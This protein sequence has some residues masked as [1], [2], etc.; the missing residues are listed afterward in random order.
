MGGIFFSIYAND[1][2]SIFDAEMYRSFE[3]INHRGLDGSILVTESTKTME[4]RQ[5]D[6]L[7]KTMTRTE[8]ERFRKKYTFAHGY[9]RMSI[10]DITRNG[11]QPFEIC[12]KNTGNIS[13]L[14]CNGE[15]YNYN[16]LQKKYNFSLESKSDVEIILHLYKKLG[17]LETINELDGEY[18]FIITD[19]LNTLDYKQCNVFVV[20]DFLGFKPLYMVYHKHREFFLFVSEMKAIPEHMLKSSNFEIEEVPPGT[21][22]SF[23]TYVETGVKNKFTKFVDLDE[24]KSTDKVIQETDNDTLYM[25]QKDLRKLVKESVIKRYILSDHK[26]G[27]LLSGGFDSNI[28]AGIIA[29]YIS[30]N[31]NETNDTLY[32]FTACDTLDS[33]DLNSSKLLTSYLKEKFPQL[34]IS[35]NI[36]C[37]NN[38]NVISGK[39]QELIKILETYNEKCIEKAIFYYFLLN[40]IKQ[41]TGIKVLLTGDGLSDLLSNIKYLNSE[42]SIFQIN[43]VESLKNLHKNTLKVLDRIGN[44]F[45]IELRCPYLDTSIVEMLLNIH[46]SLKKPM[47]F[48]LNSQPIDKYILRRSFEMNDDG[49]FVKDDYEKILPK[50]LLWKTHY[51]SS[52]SK[53][54]HD[55]LSTIF[56]GKYTEK[57]FYSYLS[58]IKYSN[59]KTKMELHFKILYDTFYPTCDR[60]V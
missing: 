1:G 56:E 38:F 52:S 54:I 45:N 11:F 17:I 21:F 27:I 53:W 4:G 16:D 10:N 36:I 5:F 34:N 2:P 39:I 33:P 19:N 35:H 20:R 49:I 48:S 47:S 29:E 7:K 3:N 42:D 14:M 43:Q 41:K 26:V 15:I 57:E 18:T 50:D 23:N 6:R 40:Y 30:K 37:L 9:H 24:Y 31:G 32:L 13:R 44:Y 46:P 51:A 55:E 28:I 12:D 8:I 25:F 22:W 60:L 58:N 59:I